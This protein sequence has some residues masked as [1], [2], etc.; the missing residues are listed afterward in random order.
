MFKLWISRSIIAVLLLAFLNLAGGAPLPRAEVP[1]P[2][3]SWVPWVLDGDMTLGCPH[4]FNNAQPRHC[5]WPGTLE[6]KTS[7]AGA[8]F[9]QNWQVYRDTWVALPGDE[10]NWPQNITVDSKPA[11]VI[12]REG[13]PALHLASGVHRI[14]G[15]FLWS[16]LPESLALPA[17]TGL[18]R[19]ELA[20]QNIAQPVRD[21]NSRLWLRQQVEVGSSSAEHL[22]LQVHRRLIDGVPL[23]FETRLRL[24]VSGKNRE[25]II[26]R[27]LLPDL[28]PKELR[29]PLPAT[30]VQDGNLKVQ[31]R[32]GAWEISLIA[33]H[34]DA[35]QALTLPSA[36][37][38]VAPEE[39]WVFAAA[40]LVRTVSV[41]GPPAVDPQQTT[42]PNEWRH[43][44]AYLMRPGASFGLKQVR[45]GDSDPAPDKLSLTRR[46]WLSFDG[47]TLTL[48][49]RI[50]GEMNRN[51]RLEMSGLAQLG[52]V[53]ID[54][55][56]QL[57][58]RITAQ[59]AG[60]EVRRGKLALTADSLLPEAPRNL[61]A[62]GWKHDFDQISLELA[63][64]AGWR[65]LH[66]GG[67]DRDDGAWTSRWNLLDFFLVIIIALTTGKLWGRCW[68]A[69]ALLMLVLTYHE[70]GAPRLAWLVL[71]VAITLLRLLPEG[72]LKTWLGW[73]KNG[74]LLVLVLM[75]LTFSTAQ[76]RNALY[77][78]LE[79]DS[80]D[81]DFSLP[82]S[83][84]APKAMPAPAPMAA[85]PANADMPAAPPPT[86][87]AN[88]VDQM[89]APE[90]ESKAKAVGGIRS[91]KRESLDLMPG[92]VPARQEYQ[93]YQSIDPKSNVQTGPGLPEWSWHEYRL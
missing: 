24:E 70:A 76:V 25:I 7:P 66:A 15:R 27:A 86:E 67:T 89:M 41:E 80:S 18:V 87:Q 26:G 85:K 51:S 48:R 46:L 44:P 69:T 72:R 32:A 22:Q 74:T 6:I 12:N 3:K 1:E 37:G 31:A 2:L 19:L 54:G 20:G 77:P 92:K 34:P 79:R 59:D 4:L 93:A 40:P 63:L 57:I 68:G 23:T 62:V 81:I 83:A 21:D 13:G 16:T 52:R 5:A 56:D 47:S 10:K 49:D 45:R 9:S 90:P 28:I 14:V 71:L 88:E 42:L 82:Q 43:L 39:V 30:L 91:A 75:I 29:S 61:L 53:N 78:V 64:P 50:Q 73:F 60:V 65:L 33:R 55:Q 38:L 84:S 35:V 8:G 11:A 36:A 58:T 17:S